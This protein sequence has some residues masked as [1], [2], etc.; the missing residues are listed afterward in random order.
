MFYDLIA[1]STLNEPKILTLWLYIHILC[2]PPALEQKL[3]PVMCP[4]VFGKFHVD[5]KIRL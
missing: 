3:M 1:Q 5:L 4:K 2:P